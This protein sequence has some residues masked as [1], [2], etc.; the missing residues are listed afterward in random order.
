MDGGSNCCD[1]LLELT[2]ECRTV[3]VMVVMVCWCYL[4]DGRTVDV[5][6]VMFCWS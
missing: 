2:C 4:C 3:D 5:L 6:T 1:S